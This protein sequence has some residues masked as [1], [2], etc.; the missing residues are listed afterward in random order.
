MSQLAKRDDRASLDTCALCP[1]LCRP[2]CPVANATGHEAAVPSLIAA[3]VVRWRRGDWPS[4]LAAEA[5]TLCTACGACGDH[6]H[7]H[8]PL[9]ALLATARS[10]LLVP[11]VPQALRELQGKGTMVAVESDDRAW[12]DV[13]SRHLEVP[14]QRWPTTDHLGV[15]AVDSQLFVEHARLLRAHCD[16]LRV[17]VADGGSARALKAAGVEITWLHEVVHDVAAGLRSCVYGGSKLGCC[18]AA[19]PLAVHHPDHAADLA[20]RWLSS[21]SSSEVCDARCR[22]HLRQHGGDVNDAIDRLMELP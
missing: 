14:I 12:S 16:G 15:H 7:I 2:A 13:L 11:P 1:R 3:A 22:N 4:S 9:P 20:A 17:V 10:Q 5:L 18:G 8:H 19:G 6:C 21:T